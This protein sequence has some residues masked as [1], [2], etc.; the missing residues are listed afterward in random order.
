MTKKRCEK[1]LWIICE[2]MDSKLFKD[3]VLLK[4]KEKNTEYSEHCLRT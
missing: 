3:A 4:K 1:K 2:K